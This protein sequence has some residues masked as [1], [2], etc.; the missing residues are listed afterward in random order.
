M[1][2]LP[3]MREDDCCQTVSFTANSV[4]TVREWDAVRQPF[5]TPHPQLSLRSCF[6]GFHRGDSIVTMMEHQACYQCPS[7]IYVQA[8][9]GRYIRPY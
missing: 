7:H 1:L 9:K 8:A 6:Q 3:K 2:N 5:A 4:Q